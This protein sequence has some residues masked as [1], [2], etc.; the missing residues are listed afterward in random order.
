MMRTKGDLLVVAFGRGA[1][2]QEKFP[3]LQGKGKVVRHLY[4]K[5][6]DT[7]DEMLLREMVEESRVLGMEAD[8]RKRIRASLQK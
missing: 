4:F 1:M 3:Q 6:G 5:E 2:L 8:E 7:V